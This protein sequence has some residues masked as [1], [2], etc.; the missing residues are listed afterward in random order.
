MAHRK[1][2]SPGPQGR[3]S[4]TP[5]P[6]LPPWPAVLQSQRTSQAHPGPLSHELCLLMWRCSAEVAR[7]PSEEVAALAA[8]VRCRGS[9][10]LWL[11]CGRWCGH[12]CGCC[13]GGDLGMGNLALVSCAQS[14]RRCS[15]VQ[16]RRR[17]SCAQTQRRTRPAVYGPTPTTHFLLWRLRRQA[18]LRGCSSGAGAARE[19]VACQ[20]GRG[21]E[22]PANEG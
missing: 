18:V 11:W 12:Y 13:R 16:T 3:P 20:R 21:S 5:L 10:L 4:E 8:V 9:V 1:T 6:A 15:C 22:W 14:R 2:P 17:C 7:R 19:W